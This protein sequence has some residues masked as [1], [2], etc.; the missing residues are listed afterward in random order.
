M[1]ACLAHQGCSCFSP[2]RQSLVIRKGSTQG[3]GSQVA[4][5]AAEQQ[6]AGGTIHR[7]RHHRAAQISRKLAAQALKA[8]LPAARI[9][10]RSGINGITDGQQ[11]ASG[12]HHRQPDSAGAQVNAQA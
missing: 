5:T 10:K 2:L 1:S 6:G 3:P 12:V 11:L 4:I 8:L 7:H 9:G